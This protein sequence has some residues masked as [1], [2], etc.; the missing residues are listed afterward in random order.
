MKLSD[1]LLP[2]DSIMID[3]VFGGAR[4]GG[5]DVLGGARGC[6]GVPATVVVRLRSEEEVVE[7]VVVV[8]AAAAV[9]VVAALD[10]YFFCAQ[11]NRWRQEMVG[12]E[13]TFQAD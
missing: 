10:I 13:H 4:N 7:K 8:A 3:G 5:S 9:G 1:W 2:R 6:G 12:G 11:G